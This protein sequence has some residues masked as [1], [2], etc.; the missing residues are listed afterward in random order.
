MLG[1]RGQEKDWDVTADNMLSH[2]LA[3]TPDHFSEEDELEV[4]AGAA[5]TE[6][7]GRRND[8]GPLHPSAANSGRCA[9]EICRDEVSSAI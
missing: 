7:G 9:L 6:N 8:V 1:Q 5:S 2:M 3:D 4:G